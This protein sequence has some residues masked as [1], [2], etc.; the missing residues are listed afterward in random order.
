VLERETR[1]RGGIVDVADRAD[2]RRDGADVGAACAEACDLLAGVEIACL[3]A[4][5]IAFVTSRLV[6]VPG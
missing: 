4:N 2:E 5:V 1:Y 6:R 3:H